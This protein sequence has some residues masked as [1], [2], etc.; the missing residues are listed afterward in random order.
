VKIGTWNVAY[1]AGGRNPDRRAILLSKYADV[2][3]LTETNAALDLG[4]EFSPV[5]SE[6]RK[7]PDKGARWVTIWSRFPVVRPVPVPD[8]R[9][10]VER[11]IR[12]AP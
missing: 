1:G 8:P 9:R 6:P 12:P 5:T 4:G 3:V 10:Q 11:S 2:W 7:V